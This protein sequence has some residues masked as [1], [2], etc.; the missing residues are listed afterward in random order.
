VAKPN[1]SNPPAQATSI[2]HVPRDSVAAASVSNP[3][4]QVITHPLTMSM[5]PDR[6]DID[7]A[8]GGHFTGS[9]GRLELSIERNVAFDSLVAAGYSADEA[10]AE[11][12]RADEYFIGELGFG[13]DSPLRI[14]GNR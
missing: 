5:Q 6:V 3:M 10:S 14:P 1:L 8:A 13:Y 9:D 12:A 7:P 4:P 11:V 2:N